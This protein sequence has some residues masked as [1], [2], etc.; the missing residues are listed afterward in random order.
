MRHMPH[1]VYLTLGILV[2]EV[3]RLLCGLPADG[4]AVEGCSR[5]QHCMCNS[6]SQ[7]TVNR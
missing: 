2:V 1:L 7:F 5:V 4:C 6:M 3:G